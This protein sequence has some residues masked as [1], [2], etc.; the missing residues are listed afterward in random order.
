MQ[1]INVVFGVS[2]HRR[3][4]EIERL[5]VLKPG[6]IF[7]VSYH[8][9]AGEI[10]SPQVHQFGQVFGVS[11]HRRVGEI[12]RLEVHQPGEIFG[13]AGH[14]CVRETERLQVLTGQTKTKTK[15]SNRRVQ[16][17]I[18]A[19]VLP[20]STISP[21][22]D[23]VVFSFQKKT[24][25]YYLN[26]CMRV[27]AQPQKKVAQT[28]RE[29]HGAT[30][31]SG[32][33]KGENGRGTSAKKGMKEKDSNERVCGPLCEKCEEDLKNTENCKLLDIFQQLTHKTINLH[34]SNFLTRPPSGTYKHG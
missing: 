24:K 13:F 9:R 23:G 3:V 12:G 1:R 33:T 15:T 2:Y 11:D 8:R 20:P 32:S 30:L 4:G 6:Q 10:E 17:K 27:N 25:L 22:L 21:H 31:K 19:V 14:L 7:G 34:R 26:N 29:R 5:Q 28:K 18:C 16:F